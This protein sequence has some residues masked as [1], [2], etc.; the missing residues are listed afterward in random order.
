[1]KILLVNPNENKIISQN[2]LQRAKYLL[3]KQ[4]LENIEVHAV[5]ASSNVAVIITDADVKTAEAAVIKLVDDCIDKY[6]NIII[7]AFSDPGLTALKKK[8]SEKIHGMGYA[9]IDMA[10]R[11]SRHFAI[12]TGQLSIVDNIYRQVKEYNMGGHFDGVISID[13]TYE[14]TLYNKEALYEIYHNTAKEFI[15]KHGT[16]VIA[17]GGAVFTGWS[18]R[19]SEHLGIKVIEGLDAALY[20]CICHEPDVRSAIKI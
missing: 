15:N 17:L 13:R 5:N 14:E 6:D 20:S 18:E 11:M 12:M 2:F 9:S 19:L 10:Y 16:E 3:K 1:M 4:C 8:Y 7:S